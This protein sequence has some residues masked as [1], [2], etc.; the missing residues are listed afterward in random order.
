MDAV[1]VELFAGELG[2]SEGLTTA[3]TVVPRFETVT[4]DGVV[5]IE[6]V[7][8]L[9]ARLGA[10]MGSELQRE[11]LTRLPMVREIEAGTFPF[12]SGQL[13]SMIDWLLRQ[14]VPK[15]LVCIAAD[16][17]ASV[18][19]E[20]PAIN[21]PAGIE[22]AIGVCACMTYLV[23][24]PA[25]RVFQELVCAL[26]ALPHELGSS[27]ETTTEAPIAGLGLLGPYLVQVIARLAQTVCADSGD[28]RGGP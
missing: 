6:S 25:E 23:D 14:F 22:R 2:E 7:A 11:L 26:R 18:F 20:L 12:A 19:E 24:G 17:Y 10:A 27:P 5:G 4:R 8:L 13:H 3:T 9:A 16:E 1:P 21:D 15:M 28:A